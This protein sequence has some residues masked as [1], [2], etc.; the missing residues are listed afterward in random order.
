M[1]RPCCSL[2]TL[3]VVVTVF[4]SVVGWVAYQL[5][6]IRQR[7]DFL[8][9]GNFSVRT[10]TFEQDYKPAPWNLRL[11]GESRPTGDFINL[12]YPESDPEVQRVRRQF[13]EMG[14]DYVR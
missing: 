14:V 6:W 13:P 8:N 4:C 5:N 2:R 11:F 7:H 9:R 12:P 10:L 1:P 3:L